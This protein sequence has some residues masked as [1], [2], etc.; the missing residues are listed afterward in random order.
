M[1]TVGTAHLAFLASY[2]QMPVTPLPPV[3]IKMSP[4]IAKCPWM[5]W[6]CRVKSPTDRSWW[7][8][9]WSSLRVWTRFDSSLY[10]AYSS[11]AFGVTSRKVSHK[12]KASVSPSVK[13]TCLSLYQL[14]RKQKPHRQ[15]WGKMTNQNFLLAA[16]GARSV[17]QTCFAHQHNTILHTSS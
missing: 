8:R 6:G 3:V 5:G 14:R 11:T 17:P 13:W 16:W 15:W 9:C 7:L 10:L 4:G 2:H 1:E 12:P